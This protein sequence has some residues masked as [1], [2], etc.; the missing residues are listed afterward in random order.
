MKT[1]VDYLKENGKFVGYI[2]KHEIILELSNNYVVMWIDEEEQ[3]IIACNKYIIENT[4]QEILENIDGTEIRFCNECGKPYDCGY[5]VDDGSWYC[6]EDCFE[7]AMDRDFRKDKWHGTEEEG[8]YGG[9][10]ENL[11]DD[12][13]WEDTGIFYTEW[14]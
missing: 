5:M 1:V 8:G 11:Q 14:N 12:G 9:F 10:Y 6:C 4:I 13:T 2:G 3:D 7:E